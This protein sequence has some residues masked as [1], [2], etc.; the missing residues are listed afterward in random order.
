MNDF[1]KIR[2]AILKNRGGLEA[3]TDGQIL[4]IWN[5]LDAATQEKYLLTTKHEE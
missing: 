5:A 4:L 1:K 2:E 3:A